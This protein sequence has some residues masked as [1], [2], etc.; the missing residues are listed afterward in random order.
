[1]RTIIFAAVFGVALLPLSAQAADDI[2]V[3]LKK[4]DAEVSSQAETITNQQQTINEMKELLKKSQPV[5]STADDNSTKNTGYFGGSLLN[6]PYIS[7]ILDAK[8]YVSNLKNN[9]L[10]GRG[11]PGYTTEAPGLRNSF[12]VDAAELLIFAPVDP[13]FNLYTNIPIS[14]EGATLE[15]AYVVTTNLPTGLQIK[16][17]RFK[18]NASRLNGQHPH[19]WDF[20]ELPLAYRSFLGPEALGGD[21]G[22]QLTWMPA[23]PIYTVL[24]FEVLQ[25]SNPLL[26]GD[27]GNWGP[28][29]FTAFA[30]VSFD[31]SDDSTLYFSPWAMFGNTKNAAILPADAITG[32]SFEMNGFSTLYGMEAIWKW[33]SGHQKLTLQGEYLYLRQGDATLNETAP[34]S[35]PVLSESFKRSQDGAYLQAVYGYDRISAGLRYDRMEILA[36]TFERGGVQQSFGSKPW[37][38]S[39]MTEYNFTEFSRIRAQFNHDRSDREGKVNNEGILQLTFTIGAHGAHSF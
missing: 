3:R 31:T 24:G 19:A 11:I 12:N 6:N 7:L 36:D 33:K 23:S 27:D 18:S 35:A 25:G 1:M 13:Y 32:N 37:R 21:N 8:G 29:A 38:I 14:T 22:I 9:Q 5:N 17:G 28:H 2:E 34:S 16:A 39:A 30:R 15:E 20:A 26:F 4:L 10:A